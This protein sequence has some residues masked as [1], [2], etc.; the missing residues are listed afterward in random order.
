[1]S[2]ET[3]THDAERTDQS[4]ADDAGRT[5]F[6]PAFG[7]YF[8]ESLVGAVFLAG[9]ALVATAPFLEPLTQLEVFATGFY[10]LFALQMFLILFWVLSA[11]VVEAPRVGAVLDG[12]ADVLPTSQRG[13]VFSTGA[14]SLALGWVNWALGLIAGVLVGQKLCRRARAEGTAVHYPLVLTGALL[15]LVVT[16]QGLSSPG[17]LL[18]ADGSGVAN[19]VAEDAGSVSMS[20]FVLHPVNL[21]STAVFV[22]TLPLLLV[23]LAPDE[24]SEIEPL[25]E[26][27]RVLEGSIAETLSHY[28]PARDHDDW[29]LGDRLENS[30]LISLATVAVGLA[31]AGWHFG[32]GGALTLPWLAFTLVVLGLLVQ[33]PPMAFR[34]K[35]EDATRWANHVAIPFL[36]YASVVALLTEADLYGPIGDA[37]AST[38]VPGA[39]SYV[40]AF[41]LGLLVPD[42][43]S[44]WVLQGPALAAADVDLAVSLIATMYGAG[45]SNLWLAFLFAGILSI[46]G[47]DWRE[48]ATYA[49]IVTLYVSAVV[50]GLLLVV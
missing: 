7:Q 18:M 39:A 50:L 45:V 26:R 34:E 38:G 27:N 15:A 36:L 2:G 30:R 46:R 22:A 21:V 29:Q 33:G 14:P 49:A 24:E 1:M 11:A 20:S 9:L 35:T 17:A 42:P 23:W 10:D 13:I 12:V 44:V 4:V 28:V 40:V 19:V 43:A 41:V 3:P 5:G 32:T 25:A 6:V 31:S 16:N 8:P 47:F 37:I 48:F